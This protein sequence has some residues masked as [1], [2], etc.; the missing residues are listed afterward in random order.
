[1][2]ILM[3][4]FVLDNEKR[5]DVACRAFY[6]SSTLNID[7]ILWHT[8]QI[9]CAENV[10]S[11]FKLWVFHFTF[12]AYALPHTFNCIVYALYMYISEYRSKMAMEYSKGQFHVLNAWNQPVEYTPSQFEPV[13]L[14]Q[15]RKSEDE[16]LLLLKIIQ[17]YYS[18]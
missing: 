4:K 3:I 2:S 8:Q 12:Q 13:L 10:K 14:R 15:V 16:F 11:W 18:V 1:M 7:L 5:F 17:L 6:I 9:V